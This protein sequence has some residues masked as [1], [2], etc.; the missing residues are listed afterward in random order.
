MDLI[1]IKLGGSIITD[2]TK[3]LTLRKEVLNRLIK[4][5]SELDNNCRYIVVHG[6]GSFGHVLSKKYNLSEGIVDENTMKYVD[7]V[8]SDV[9]KLS[10]EVLNSFNNVNLECQYILS[11]DIIKSSNKKIQSMKLDYIED[12]LSNNRIPILSGHIVRDIEQGVSIAS[13]EDILFYIAKNINKNYKVKKIIMVGETDGVYKL[14]DG[15]FSNEIYLNINKNN[16]KS[17]KGNILKREGYDVT[18][19][20]FHKIEVALDVAKLGIETVLIN[21]NKED[22]LKKAILDKDI[23]GTIVS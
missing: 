21:G 22:M 3:L 23:T 5:L 14:E 8:N 7:M 6:T 20:M 18:G 1:L 12:I 10:K 16:F 9:S 19:G 4:E 15:Q 2:K 11:S 17:I 13:G